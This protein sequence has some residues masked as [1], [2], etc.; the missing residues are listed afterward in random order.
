[1]KR[2]SLVVLLVV[3]VVLLN[4]Y[5]TGQDRQLPDG[6][7]YFGERTLDDGTKTILRVEFP[8]GLKQFDVTVLP[9]RTVKLGRVESPDGTKNFDAT[10]FPDGTIK[11]GRIEMSNN[12]KQ[13]DVTRLPEDTVKY[14]RVE[15]PDGT[16]SFN[17]TRLPDGT[18][19]TERVEYPSGEKQ[20]DE[21]KFP[22]R[23][24]KV[25]RVE[26]P[27]G[28]KSYD[29]T[30][31]PDGTVKTGRA[32]FPSGVKN[33]DVV[34]LPNGTKKIGRVEFPDGQKKFD[35]ALAADGTEVNGTSTP[36][37]GSAALGQATPEQRV[38]T[39]VPSAHPTLAQDQTP[40]QSLIDFVKGSLERYCIANSGEPDPA[41]CIAQHMNS[42]KYRR[43]QF[44]I[45]NMDPEDGHDYGWLIEF[46]INDCEI[47]ANC[48]VGFAIPKVGKIA[49]GQPAWCAGTSACL[50]YSSPNDPNS[51]AANA[52]VENARQLKNGWWFALNSRGTLQSVT[53]ARG[54]TQLTPTYSAIALTLN[55]HTWRYYAD[56]GYY[57]DED[58][59]REKLAK[60]QKQQ[61]QKEQNQ[62]D[63]RRKAFREL[64]LHRL[65]SQAQVK[66][67]LTA[68]G[69]APWQ[70]Q[71]TRE[72]WERDTT[73]ELMLLSGFPTKCSASRHVG[74]PNQDNV[75]LVFAN[76]HRLVVA[77]YARA[78]DLKDVVFGAA[79]EPF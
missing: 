73:G 35:V 51:L 59:N 41:A 33:F 19:K 9:D 30:K 43:L 37:A 68:H 8:N 62:L 63:D 22:D 50:E 23:T 71:T 10:M 55:G 5:S 12:E 28:T 72:D 18:V 79:N 4:G 54:M 67:L 42:A 36:S 17:V 49:G 77:R 44:F 24:V 13:F 7:K 75:I 78:S 6:T 56:G 53:I 2:T 32:E 64:G 20:F 58:E 52:A 45:R 60:A 16:K 46:N 26:F 76:S 3:A 1:M 25:G 14:G 21:T 70:C 66:S 48:T 61:L 31:L 39:A 65:Q 38:Q 47:K 15:F 69:F 34:K 74:L 29:E 11:I 40:P 27:D 57:Y